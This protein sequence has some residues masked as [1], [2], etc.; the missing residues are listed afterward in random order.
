MGKKTPTYKYCIVPACR[1]TTTASPDKYFF[2]VPRKQNVRNKWCKVIS[3]IN[4]QPL[5]GK[6][7]LH[8]CEDH[9]NVS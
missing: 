9:F 7:P 8:C 6:T 2:S 5:S 3:R 4:K 1:N